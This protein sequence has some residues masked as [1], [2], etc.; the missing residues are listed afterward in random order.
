[1][2]HTVTDTTVVLGCDVG[3]THHQFR[4][5]DPAMNRLG[6]QRTTKTTDAINQTFDWA[7]SLNNSGV[8]VLVID[9]KYA[10]NAPT[11]RR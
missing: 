1:M 9:Q 4:A 2:G 6:R 7:R 5:I 10:A 3:K 8:V 11:L